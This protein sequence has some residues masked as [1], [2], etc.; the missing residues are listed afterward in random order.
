MKT[1]LVIEDDTSI[2]RGLKDNLEYEGY[3]VVTET[4]G[5]RGLQA[6]LSKNPYLILLDI[7]L[8]GMNGNEICRRVKKEKPDLP[9]IMITARG[10]EMDKVSGLDIG[11][12]DYI[13]KP[14]SIP[15]LLAR[16]RAVMRRAAPASVAPDQHAFGKVRLDFKKLQAFREDMEIKLSTKEFEIMKY[17]ITHEGEAVHRHDLLNAVWGYEAM[18]TTRTVD[19]FI[20]DL[21]K[22][23][24]ED[25]SKPRHIIGIR[26]VGYKFLS[27]NE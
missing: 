23:L 11:A 10:S 21:R 18:P 20:L 26:D 27:L 17:L 9:V 5:E 7:M 2:L 24:E 22:K 14:F 15:E 8:P 4:N 25:P 12:D 6:A 3:A 1:I 19:N 16:I 13:T